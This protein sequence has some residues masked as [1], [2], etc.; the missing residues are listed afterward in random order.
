MFG[1]RSRQAF[2]GHG[3]AAPGCGDVFRGDHSSQHPVDEPRQHE[4]GHEWSG[5][6]RREAPGGPEEALAGPRA[7]HPAAEKGV[8]E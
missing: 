6:A 7:G 2:E 8:G 5:G 3:F 4:R 1:R